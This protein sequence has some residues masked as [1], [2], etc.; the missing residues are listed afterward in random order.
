MLKWQQFG[1]GGI[2]EHKQV[3]NLVNL[4]IKLAEK[5]FGKLPEQCYDVEIELVKSNS[6]NAKAHYANFAS[7]T[8]FINPELVEDV[9]WAVFHEMEH[10]RT[11]VYPYVSAYQTG[12]VVN[13]KH[14]NNKE[15]CSAL[16]EGLTEISVERLLKRK[17]ENPASVELCNLTRQFGVLLGLMDDNAL[18][19]IYKTD[20]Y[21][22]LKSTFDSIMDIKSFNAFDGMQTALDSLNKSL[23]ADLKLETANTLGDEPSATE[24]SKQ[25]KRLKRFV[26]NE[27]LL[28]LSLQKEKHKISDAEFTSRLKAMRKLASPKASA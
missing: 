6:V 16:N 12:L 4:Y 24:F 8:L 23:V 11:A 13:F 14:D 2:M 18:L 25:T 19:K 7:N 26:Q 3:E 5:Q 20:G 17:N 10:I 9:E 1:L 27:Y 21:D 22:E 15:I 28:L